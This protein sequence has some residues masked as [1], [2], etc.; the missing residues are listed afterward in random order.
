[1]A[2][3]PGSHVCLFPCEPLGLSENNPTSLLEDIKKTKYNSKYRLKA[4][5]NGWRIPSFFAWKATLCV[6]EVHT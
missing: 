3:I 6:T 5:K 1:L 2:A 4:K